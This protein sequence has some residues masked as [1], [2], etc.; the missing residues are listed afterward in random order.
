MKKS[1]F[2][3]TQIQEVANKSNT[4]QFIQ[5][6]KDNKVNYSILDQDNI[7]DDN[8]GL[9]N[10]EVDGMDEGVFL[11]FADGRYQE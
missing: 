1:Q 11:L 6:L 3:Q 4:S 7:F 2:N 8:D 5:F 9:V 10:I